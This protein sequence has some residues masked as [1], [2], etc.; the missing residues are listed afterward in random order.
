MR[1]VSVLV[2]SI[3]STGAAPLDE[4]PGPLSHREKGQEHW[5]ACTQRRPLLVWHL[6]AL[7]LVCA[8]DARNSRRGL[9]LWCHSF[10]LYH[11]SC[12]IV[13]YLRRGHI[14]G[15]WIVPTP[16]GTVSVVVAFPARIWPA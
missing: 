3:W 16:P 11:S 14:G 12:C 1:A 15:A 6:V 4:R 8:V 13:R 7:R 5:L 9:W 2:V 10:L